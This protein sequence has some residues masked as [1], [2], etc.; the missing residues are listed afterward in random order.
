MKSRTRSS[1]G[2]AG[3]KQSDCQGKGLKINHFPGSDVR[4]WDWEIGAGK[5]GQPA[6]S[7]RRRPVSWNRVPARLG[8]EWAVPVFQ[9]FFN[10]YSQ[11]RARM[12]STRVARRAGT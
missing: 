5:L 8:T 10:F 7:T 2:M 3:V 11:R 1:L 4:W 9:A 6:L 12:G